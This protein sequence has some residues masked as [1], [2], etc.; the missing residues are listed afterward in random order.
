MLKANLISN[1]QT[2]FERGKNT[3]CRATE[4]TQEQAASVTTVTQSFVYLVFGKL[5]NGSIFA[6]IF[7]SQLIAQ[8]CLTSHLHYHVLGEIDLFT[9]GS[10]SI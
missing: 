7:F 1:N 6:Y 9:P 8:S 2:Y 5:H 3:N 10:W 4:L